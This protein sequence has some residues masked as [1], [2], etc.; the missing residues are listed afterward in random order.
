MPLR[1]VQINPLM[2]NETRLIKEYDPETEVVAIF[3]VPPSSVHAY[4]GGLAPERLSP[5]QAYEKVGPV[6]HLN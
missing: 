2:S 5:R 1:E 3:L 4:R 6:L